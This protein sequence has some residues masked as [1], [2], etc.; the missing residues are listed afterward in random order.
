MRNVHSVSVSPC[1][2]NVSG[3]RLAPVAILLLGMLISLIPSLANAQ[4]KKGVAI[5]RGKIAYDKTRIK[6]HEGNR[7]VIPY[8]EIKAK[9][10]QKVDPKPA[11]FP[12]GF[13]K[14]TTQAKLKWEKDFLATPQG[15]RLVAQNKKLIENANAFDVKFEKDGKFVIYDVPYGTYGI[16]GRTDKKINGKEYAF[17]VFGEI[18]VIN[19]MDDIPLKPMRVEVT[20]LIRSGEVA[21]PV[22]VKTHDDKLTL[23]LDHKAFKGK[24]VFLNFWTSKSPSSVAEQKM[25]QEMYSKLKGKHQ[26]KLVSICVDDNRGKALQYIIKNKLKEGSHGFTGGVEHRTI[27]DYGVRSFPSFCLIGKDRKVVMS[28]FEVSQAMRLKPNLETIVE[29]RISGKDQPTPAAAEEP[30][31]A[32]G[33]KR[34]SDEG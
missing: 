12:R 18:P 32:A 28:Q 23:R 24:M 17:E 30:T 29:D 11:P 2:S 6:S 34:G 27:F 13:A 22:A 4:D 3:S 1:L 20:P 14:F 16:Q 15:K 7:L 31:A 33:S 26:M 21:P 25:V 8:K 19:G 5:I 10:R 9:I